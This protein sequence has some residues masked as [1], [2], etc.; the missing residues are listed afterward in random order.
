MITCTN[1]GY[2]NQLGAQMTNFADLYYLA[3]ENNQ[4][5]KLLG[6][7]EKYRR[8][9]QFVEVFDFPEKF[10]LKARTGIGGE[11]STMPCFLVNLGTGEKIIKA[12]MK[13]NY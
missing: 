12:Y 5:L 6:E 4:E 9:Y 11:K 13:T 7:L 2:G 3:R 10:I 8:G 1:I